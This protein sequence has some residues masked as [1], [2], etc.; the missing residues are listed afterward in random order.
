MKLFITAATTLALLA[1][2]SVAQDVRIPSLRAY[3]DELK[4]LSAEEACQLPAE[5]AGSIDMVG[6]GKVFFFSKMG[7]NTKCVQNG[8]STRTNGS[9]SGISTPE[10]CANKCVEDE[11]K[12]SKITGMNFNCAAKTCSCLYGS[13]SI[14]DTVRRNGSTCYTVTSA[15]SGTYQLPDGERMSRHCGEKSQFE[16]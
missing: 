14:E 1:Q 9:F 11:A 12:V 2:Q 6:C 8:G 13:G 3:A 16:L 4:L 10:D 15:I 7:G 5:V